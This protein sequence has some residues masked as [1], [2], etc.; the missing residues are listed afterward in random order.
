MLKKPVP[1]ISY[2]VTVQDEAKGETYNAMGTEAM[3]ITVY[4][5]LQ[6]I[7]N[8][9]ATKGLI[10]D[11]TYI[12]SS[13]QKVKLDK[14]LVILPWSPHKTKGRHSSKLPTR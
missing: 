8:K 1:V 4:A 5:L 10:H 12:N 2:K 3:G 11:L 9:K 7:K 6:Q 13:G 14:K